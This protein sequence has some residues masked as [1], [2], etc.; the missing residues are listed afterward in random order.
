MEKFK[1][2]VWTLSGLIDV[3]YNHPDY[4]WIPLTYDQEDPSMPDGLEEYLSDAD[5]APY[6]EGKNDMAD[7][8][9]YIRD[10]INTLRDQAIASGIEYLGA[11]YDTDPKS[12]SNING[13]A[14]L[15]VIANAAGQPFSIEWT[16]ED[17]SSVML[18]GEQVTGLAQ[19]VGWQIGECHRVSRMHKEVIEALIVNGATADQ[20]MEADVTTGWPSNNS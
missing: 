16:L 13:A 12:I 20:I 3:Q 7:A 4:G 1:N 5:I 19:A 15:A 14:T 10:V 11:R 18:D 17:D 9:R 8:R 2:P 6:Q